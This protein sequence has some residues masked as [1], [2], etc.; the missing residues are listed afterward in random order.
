MNADV[1]TLDPTETYRVELYLRSL[2]PTGAYERQEAVLDRLE[3]LAERGR[4]ESVS[5]TVWG[6]RI[7]QRAD[8]RDEAG[9]AILDDVDRLRAWAADHDA[10][11]DPFF[12]E[13]EGNSLVESAHTVLIP[14]V[15]CLAIR[16]DEGLR[17]VFPCATDGET[18]TVADGLDALEDG[19][20]ADALAGGVPT[21]S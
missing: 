11:L 5:S 12:E 14:P 20:P 9:H 19:A 6:D 21:Q 3:C 13:R 7:R 2:A 17:G 8:L 18:Y 10:S 4:V 16:D 1:S 15:L